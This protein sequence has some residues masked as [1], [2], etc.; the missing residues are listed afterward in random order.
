MGACVEK[1]KGLTMIRMEKEMKKCD[2]MVKVCLILLVMREK[3][4]REKGGVHREM[5]EG[6]EMNYREN[7]IEIGKAVAEKEPIGGK[8]WRRG[9]TGI[10]KDVIVWGVGRKET[11]STGLVQKEER[12][13]VPKGERLL[14]RKG[15]SG[16][17]Q[18]GERHPMYVGK[19]GPLQRGESGQVEKGES[20]LA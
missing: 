14:I 4:G 12:G 10:M 16:L 5:G 3:E 13:L 9:Q 6:I 19:S 11:L 17:V 2:K 7:T 15:E 20:G 1:L 18:E 8:E